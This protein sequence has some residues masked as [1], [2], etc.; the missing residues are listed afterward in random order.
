MGKRR[1]AYGFL[2]RRREGKRPIG[3]TRCTWTDNIKMKFITGHTDIREIGYFLSEIGYITFG[4]AFVT[5]V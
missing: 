5:R 2:V 1:G 3:R 4:N